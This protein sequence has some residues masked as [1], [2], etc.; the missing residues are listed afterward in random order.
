M[1][2][3]QSPWETAADVPLAF[4]LWHLSRALFEDELA[5]AGLPSARPETLF[6]GVLDN[7][8][9]LTFLACVDRTPLPTDIAWGRF[10]L[11]KVEVSQ[12]RGLLGSA[13][14]I[15][16]IVSRIMPAVFDIGAPAAQ[17]LTD[18]T[19]LWCLSRLGELYR[20]DLG[21]GSF[22]LFESILGN[23]LPP[24]PALSAA[25]QR[26][27]DVNPALAPSPQRP[28]RL[29]IQ[30][31]AELD[32]FQHALSLAVAR[33]IGQRAFLKHRKYCQSAYRA[34]YDVCDRLALRL[35]HTGET[36]ASARVLAARTFARTATEASFEHAVMSL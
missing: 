32:T 1:P 2:Y 3:P 35:V 19:A 6:G 33:K 17:T 4:S 13:D 11:P 15:A 36:P 9:C 18:L 28:A 12:E 16:D 27:I 30:A 8:E 31:F 14:G 25:T 26:L 5:E 34:A 23:A 10:N 22:N 29:T 20:A 7:I 21:L 24:D